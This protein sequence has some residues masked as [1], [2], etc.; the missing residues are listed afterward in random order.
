MDLE[1]FSTL[2]FKVGT[3]YLI[4][5]YDPGLAAPQYRAYSVSGSSSLLGHNGQP[6][7]CW[8]LA[9]SSDKNKEVFWI[10]KKTKEVLKLEQE[11]NGRYRYKIKLPFSN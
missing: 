4:N 5:F 7:D 3:T 9:H 8:L 1:V 2:L 6:V 11:S 10:S